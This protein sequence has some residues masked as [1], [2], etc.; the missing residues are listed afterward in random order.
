MANASQVN[1]NNK[2][3]DDQQVIRMSELYVVRCILI[4]L[5]TLIN[6]R[7]IFLRRKGIF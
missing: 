1:K 7:R 2:V 5:S 4:L 6:F 3:K